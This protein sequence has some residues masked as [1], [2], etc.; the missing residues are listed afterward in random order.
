MTQVFAD[1]VKYA[2]Q[3]RVAL[4]TL[5]RAARLNA[6]DAAMYQGVNEA[7]TAFHA[8]D[9]AWVAVIQAAGDKAFNSRSLLPV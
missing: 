9:D 2:V 3:D 4:I 6:F 1:R 7:L 5:E 8:D